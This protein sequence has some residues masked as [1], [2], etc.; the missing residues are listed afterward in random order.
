MRNNERDQANQKAF[1]CNLIKLF[2]V[3]TID[4]L[5]VMT[6]EED[7][8]FLMMQRDDVFSCRMTGVDVLLARKEERKRAREERFR[9]FARKVTSN[10]LFDSAL[11]HGAFVPSSSSSSLSPTYCL[12]SE[13]SFHA[14]DSVAISEHSGS[15]SSTSSSDSDEDFHDHSPRL[16][17]EPKRAKVSNIFRNSNVTAALDRVNVPDRGAT[18]IVGAV[19]QAL[20]HDVDTMTLSRSSIRRSR[21]KNREEETAGMDKEVIGDVPLLLHW[22]GKL[23]PDITGEKKNN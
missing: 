18:F 4:A 14:T 17:R 22:D 5:S 19:A 21:Y 1:K 3:A 10:T 23:L 15:S 6:I 12:D 11:P 16:K 20:G 13:E 9:N 8:Q 2:D 7:K